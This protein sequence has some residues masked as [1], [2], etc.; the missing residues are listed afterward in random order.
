MIMNKTNLL[1]WS[2]PNQFKTGD[3]PFSYV[4]SPYKISECSFFK[5]VG[6]SR[7]LLIYFRRYNTVDRKQLIVFNINFANDWIRTTDLWS[8]KQLLYQLSHNHCPNKVDFCFLHAAL[9]RVSKIGI[10][11]CCQNPAFFHIIYSPRNESLG[12]FCDATLYL[13]P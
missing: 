4:S 13:H 1:V 10:P 3:Q 2:N 11:E 9:Q 5:I 7:P 6:R 8:L 12:T